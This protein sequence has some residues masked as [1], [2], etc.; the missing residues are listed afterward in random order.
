MSLGLLAGAGTTAEAAPLVLLTESGFGQG[1]VSIDSANPAMATSTMSFI[2]GLAAG[3]RVVGIDYRPATGQLYALGD[4][5]G[6]YTVDPASGAATLVGTGFSNALNGG[7]HGFGFDF[8][9]VIDRIRIVSD[10]N[11]NF[12]AH[13][14][15]GN[16]NV[17]VTSDVFYA[18]GDVNA[19]RDPNVVHHAYDRNFAGTS[20]TQL[21]A[22]DTR[23]NMLVKQAN[24]AG[25]L[26]TVGALGVDA[27][28]IG[29]F[30]ISAGNL[31]FAVFAELGT[32]SS[33]LYQLDLAS[34]AAT[35]LGRIGAVV[36]GVAVAPVPL[37]AGLPLLSLA[38]AGLVGIGRSRHR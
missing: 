23:L 20:A 9:P 21:Y 16:A 36:S 14:D 3:E 2:T 11:Q 10:A 15:T 4:G 25:T 33:V 13:P 30:D 26:T 28:D 5:S 18:A 12:V 35:E 19:G 24:N 7:T 6:V 32:G 29:G 1:L 38:L 8:N 17:A 34:G 22:I 37:P 31:A 27:G